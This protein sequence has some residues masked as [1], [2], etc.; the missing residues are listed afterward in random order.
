VDRPY[1]FKSEARLVAQLEYPHIVPLYDYWQ[2]DEGAFLVMR[3][4]RGGTLK[5]KLIKGGAFTLEQA[6]ELMQQLL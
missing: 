6:T 1:P 2:D 4:I 3:F 5:K